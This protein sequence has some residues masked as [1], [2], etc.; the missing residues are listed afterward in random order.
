VW[1]TGAAG[2]V[3]SIWCSVP[4]GWLAGTIDTVA[5]SPCTNGRPGS[6]PRA[7]VPASVQR[8]AASL[9]VVIDGCGLLSPAT[10]E[11]ITLI[12]GAVCTLAATQPDEPTW[13]TFVCAVV[14]PVTGKTAHM[15][16]RV[17]AAQ[18]KAFGARHAPALPAPADA[19]SSR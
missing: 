2:W 18:A 13:E 1:S 8:P 17:P 12:D 7:R 4:G 15:S 9:H 16:V 10:A 19:G 11:A 6:P 5:T 3:K 14:D